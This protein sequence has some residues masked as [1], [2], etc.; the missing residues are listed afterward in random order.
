MM[1]VGKTKFVLL[2]LNLISWFWW[3]VNIHPTAFAWNIVYDYIPWT[4]TRMETACKAEPG[5]SC[6]SRFKIH[7]LIIQM[8]HGSLWNFHSYTSGMWPRA[9]PALYEY[10]N[11]QNVC[12]DISDSWQ[13]RWV[14][15]LKH[16]CVWSTCSDCEPQ[17]ILLNGVFWFTC[18]ICCRCQY[19]CTAAA[20]L[21]HIVI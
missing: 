7:P 20:M 13:W 21:W 15:F 4:S 5:S 19:C 18:C 6:S 10:I 3:S 8:R 2:F 16:W 11:G 9:R 14:W 17:M 12:Q 1:Q